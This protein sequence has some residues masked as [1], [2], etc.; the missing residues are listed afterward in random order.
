MPTEVSFECKSSNNHFF[1][2][3]Y[4][5][6]QQIQF[7]KFQK[8]IANKRRMQLKSIR[9]PFQLLWKLQKFYDGAAEWKMWGK[10][11]LSFNANWVRRNL[12]WLKHLL[13]RWAFGDAS[14][15]LSAG[16]GELLCGTEEIYLKVKVWDEF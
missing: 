10:F 13:A 14:M 12:N 9:F 1:L 6:P 7:S 8:P 16:M 15:A 5:Q 11:G 4:K 3:N 2:F